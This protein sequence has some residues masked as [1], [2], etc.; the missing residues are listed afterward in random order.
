[1]QDGGEGVQTA[2]EEGRFDFVRAAVYV[3]RLLAHL[4]W[5]EGIIWA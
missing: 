5:E 2:E 1:M 3:F 4:R